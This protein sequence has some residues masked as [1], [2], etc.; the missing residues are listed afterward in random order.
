[1]P[2]AAPVIV[3]GAAGVVGRALRPLLGSRDFDYTDRA[4][5]DVTRSA[6]LDAAIEGRRVVLHLGSRLRHP[7]PTVASAAESVRMARNVVRSALSKRVP[8]VILMSS[9]RA[10]PLPSVWTGRERDLRWPEPVRRAGMA[11]ERLGSRA[12]A[13]G[14]DVIVIRLGGVCW[15]DHPVPG[16]ERAVWLSH[17]DCADLIRRCIE[18]PIEPGRCVTFVAVSDTR[19]RVHDTTNPLGWVSATKSVGLG[20]RLHLRRVQIKSALKVWLQRLG[21]WR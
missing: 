19:H 3:T 6:D 14:L 16:L 20:R 8:R 17:A 4:E 5:L 13:R 11:I 2:G 21:L 15:P 7:G 9:V 1:M 18:A 12:A 10:A